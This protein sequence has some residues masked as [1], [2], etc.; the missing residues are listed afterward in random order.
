MAA[1]NE[2]HTLEFEPVLATIRSPVKLVRGER[3]AWLDPS[4][5]RRLAET[6]PGADVTLIPDAGHFVMEDAPAEVAQVLLDFF[7]QPSR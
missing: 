1:F 2:T 4:P 6:V 7:D 5:A 3:D